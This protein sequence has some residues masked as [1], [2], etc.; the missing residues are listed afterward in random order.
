MN[1]RDNFSIV[2]RGKVTPVRLALPWHPADYKKPA[3]PPKIFA[4]PP[5]DYWVAIP[6][7]AQWQYLAGDYPRGKDWTKAGFDVK[8]WKTGAAG[9][10]YGTDG[11]KTELKDMEG[12]YSTIYLRREFKIEQADKITE[13]GLMIDY[14]DGF[15]AYLNG[16]E[17]ARVNVDRSS[18]RNAQGVKFR[19]EF[20]YAYVSLKD[21]HKHLRDGVN[22][23]SIEGHNFKKEKT[24]FVLDPYLIVED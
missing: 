24:D 23:L 6:Q 5:I 16:R 7:N 14:D 15:I 4:T 12:K 10:G 18:G 20:G 21:V 17:V 9:F 22:V 1:T 11:V 13:L 2:K 8:G 19:N 3:N